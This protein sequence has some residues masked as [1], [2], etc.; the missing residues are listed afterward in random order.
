MTEQ[1]FKSLKAGD[2]V[3]GVFSG[4]SYVVA[5]NYGDRVTAVRTVDVTNP[6]EWQLASKVTQREDPALKL[7]DSCV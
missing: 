5:A 4:Q 7:Q 3:R 1:Q 6:H 2:I